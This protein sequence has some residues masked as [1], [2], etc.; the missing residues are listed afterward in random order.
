MVVAMLR[1]A[2]R[3]KDWFKMKKAAHMAES[4]GSHAFDYKPDDDVFITQGDV[5]EN[6]YPGVD[7]SDYDHNDPY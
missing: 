7:L 2:R 3:T 1:K 6:Q 5:K 4:M